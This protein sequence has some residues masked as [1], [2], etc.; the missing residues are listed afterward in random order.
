MTPTRSYS[1]TFL[2]CCCFRCC[3]VR[4]KNQRKA[5]EESNGGMLTCLQA[6]TRLIGVGIVINV[7]PSFC[8]EMLSEPLTAFLQIFIFI[9]IFFLQETGN[10]FLLSCELNKSCRGLQASTSC[11]LARHDPRASYTDSTSEHLTVSPQALEEE[12]YFTT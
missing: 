11:A 8:C 9:F 4:R 7:G 2:T 12:N 10:E 1:P 3:L 5:G 6:L